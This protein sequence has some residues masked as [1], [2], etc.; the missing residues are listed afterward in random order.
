[1]NRYKPIGWRNESYRHSLAA[2]GIK[3][4]VR[5]SFSP[6]EVKGGYSQRYFIYKGIKFLLERA[7]DGAGW[8]CD[9]AYTVDGHHPVETEYFTEGDTH[10]YR[11]SNVMKGLKK[12]IDEGK[13]TID[14]D[15]SYKLYD[16][17]NE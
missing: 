6:M 5:M 8:Y 15:R 11:M 1:M 2:K 12:E 17:N 10:Y 14:K 7:D 16:K 13:Y 3:T 4:K 9:M